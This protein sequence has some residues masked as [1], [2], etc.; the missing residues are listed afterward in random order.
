MDRRAM[1]QKLIGASLF[2]LAGCGR[3]PCDA[4]ARALEDELAALQRIAL[5]AP[6]H[7][8]VESTPG[9][10]AW[11]YRAPFAS[12]WLAVRPSELPPLFVSVITELDVISEAEP[13]AEVQG[14][15]ALDILRRR[16][17]AQF[18]SAD[19]EGGRVPAVVSAD[20][21]VPAA[22][23]REVLAVAAAFG[24]QGRVDVAFRREQ[25]LPLRRVPPPPE[26]NEF[27]EAIRNPDSRVLSTLREPI[28]DRIFADCPLDASPVATSPASDRAGMLDRMIVSAF[29]DCG[30]RADERAILWSRQLA[31]LPDPAIGVLPLVPAKHGVELTGKSWLEA[32]R[33]LLAVASRR[34]DP[35][36][37]VAVQLQS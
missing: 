27:D 32:S 23:M 35:L 13:P 8:F 11:E 9:D 4:R 15:M 12:I 30:C 17:V 33:M 5:H 16:L 34:T 21:T 19:A 25:P 36:L 7:K 18:A 14:V 26:F 31:L 2:T 6:G 37:P 22:S 29:R 3:E 20:P 24:P 10:P 1:L 28:V